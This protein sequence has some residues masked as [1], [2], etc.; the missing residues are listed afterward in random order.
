MDKKDQKQ[1]P[2]TFLLCPEVWTGQKDAQEGQ[3]SADHIWSALSVS[4]F[5]RH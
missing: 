1:L 2:R 3:K 4:I 5:Y